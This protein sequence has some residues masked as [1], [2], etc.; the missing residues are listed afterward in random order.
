MREGTEAL[1]YGLR[2]VGACAPVVREGTEALPY[3]IIVG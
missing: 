1:P 2:L 3:G